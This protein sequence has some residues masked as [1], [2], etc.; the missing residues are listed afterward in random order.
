MGKCQKT[1]VHKSVVNKKRTKKK[2]NMTGKV[3]NSAMK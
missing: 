3:R 1:A 2:K